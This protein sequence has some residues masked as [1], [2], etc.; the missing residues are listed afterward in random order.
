MYTLDMS[1]SKNE[2]AQMSRKS[3]LLMFCIIAG[4][5]GLMISLTPLGVR[6]EE[7]VGL[8]LLFELRGVRQ[9]PSDVLIVAI[10]KESAEYLNL[11]Y[12]PVK[13]PRSLYARIIDILSERGASVIAFDVYF[14]EP[15]SEV[16]DTLFA[17]S[18]AR[19]GNVVL[20]A[21]LKQELQ[22]LTDDAGSTNGVASI[23]K[24]VPPPDILHRSAA[25]IA[26]FP[27]PKVPV[28]VN[29]YWPFK[30]GS[31]DI[32][33]L[34]VVA[35][36][37]F[38]LNAY[39]VFIGLLTEFVP[40][41]AG[42][43]PQSREE[44]AEIRGLEQLVQTIRDI[45][46][47]EPHLADTLREELSRRQAGEH[48]AEMQLIASL[49]EMYQ[50]SGSRYLNFY[51]PPGTIDTIGFYEI[52]RSRNRQLSDRRKLDLQGKAVFVGLTGDVRPEQTDGFYTVFSDPRGAHITGVEMAATAFANIREN[53]TINPISH[54]LHAVILVLWGF[55]LVFLCYRLGA[56]LSAIVMVC[57]A[58]IY[59]TFVYLQFKSSGQ[60]YPLFVPIVCQAP[61]AYL[62]TYLWKFHDVGVERDRIRTALGY[63]MPDKV[64]DEL[65][66]TI[67]RPVAS[68]DLVYGT[69]LFTDAEKYSTLSERITPR[70][71]S[72]FMNNYYEAIF[73]PVRAH[74]GIVSD[75]IG[76]SM[77]AI[78]AS[79]NP[80]SDIRKHA[81][82]AALDID[83]AV[84]QFNK[85]SGSLRLPTRIGVDSGEMSM[86]HIGALDHYEYRAVGDCVN[87]ASKLEGLN[88][89]L[90]TRILVSD[91]VLH[92][93]D[94]FLTREVGSFLLSGKSRPVVIHELI[95]LMDECHDHQ[96]EVC[97][98]FDEALTAFRQRNWTAAMSLFR[99]SARLNE[100]DGPSHFYMRL[101]GSY[102]KKPPDEEWTGVI[103]V[104]NDNGG[105]EEKHRKGSLSTMSK[106]MITNL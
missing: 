73:A 86:G 2:D 45:F 67:G 10:G 23:E 66:R 63:H 38:A 62:M 32:P 61:V 36:Q 24:L 30:L 7:N 11:S 17:E 59:I 54:A 90:G 83:E 46:Q 29:E 27:L 85:S 58:G 19:A 100:G 87:T 5:L 3:K 65:A 4:F 74:G 72:S 77:M 40:G 57:A 94:M 15:Q 43:L 95:C 12:N 78:W 69:C 37:I 39:D 35:F 26:A 93:L 21:Y 81:C 71:L 99:K 96:K 6:L 55:V 34:P 18:I 14:S 33:T 56:L 60:W 105:Y 50:W 104:G 28:R 103:P 51:G 76:D 80:D 53:V 44:L 48:A 31:G 42:K 41:K 92:D 16:Y 70:D 75:V 68:A 64:A 97:R 98:I 47:S 8:N 89:Y 9:P 79:I 82:M 49:I 101:C 52:L 20:C 25:A 106:S 91:H 1:P 88:K 102:R 22:H 84:E 13:W